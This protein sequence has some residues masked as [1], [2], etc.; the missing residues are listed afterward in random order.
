MTE[1]TFDAFYRG[2]ARRLTRYAYGLV[3][4]PGDAQDL[5][6]EAYARA[7]V[8][9]F[10]NRAVVTWQTESGT[11]GVT[12]VDVRTGR[13]VWGPVMLGSFDESAMSFWHP[14][15]VLVGARND[16]GSRPDGAVFVLD[17]GTGKVL[18]R[19]DVDNFE[20]DDLVVGESTLVMGSRRDRVT[21]GYDLASGRVRWAVPDPPS[22]VVHSI[23]MESWSD[24]PVAS[25]R[26]L[27]PGIPVATQ[28]FVQLTADGAVIL[29]DLAT[30]AEVARRP[31]AVSPRG[32]DG[33]VDKVLAVD[34]VLYSVGR[35]RPGVVLA[36]NLSRPESSASVYEAAAGV[37]IGRMVVCGTAQVCVDERE[38]QS[39]NGR[40]VAFD[41]HGRT[42]R[43]RRD[44]DLVQHL[45]V[46]GGQGPRRHHG[47]LD[48]HH[49]CGTRPDRSATAGR[50]GAARYRGMGRRQRCPAL[51]AV[52]RRTRDRGVR[53]RAARQFAG[54]ARRDPRQ[55][56]LRLDR[57]PP[58]LR[59]APRCRGVALRGSVRRRR[60]QAT[61]W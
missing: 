39:V 25:L 34:G 49:R 60:D 5:V 20:A 35:D 33:E 14:R 42:V 32:A 47:L 45:Q 6:Q 54:V 27:Q 55:P 53:R 19:V 12:A 57:Q 24:R 59:D 11:T 22:G 52:R 38:V 16:N 3:G 13:A 21:D 8:G 4:D 51:P 26:N 9:T 28:Q 37:W 58:R 10:G 48:R 7:T 31:D 1:Q 29:R 61:G 43:W 23:P 2:T 46:L 40:L 44:V 17:P 15:Y 41:V 18:L 50:A 56:R 36:R 30:G